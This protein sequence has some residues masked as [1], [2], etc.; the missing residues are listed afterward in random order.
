MDKKQIIRV[1]NLTAN[2]VYYNIP[3]DNI[4]R[5]FGPFEEK[6]LTYEEIQK[7]YYQNGGDVLI[8][9]YLQIK[10]KEVALEFGVEEESFENEYSWDRE[11]VDK[12]LT[13]EH[14][15][16]LH[17]ALDFAPEGIVDLI[18]S[19]AIRLR[20]VDINKR[21][22]IQECTGKNINNMIQNQIDLEKELGEEKKE[23]PKR[24]RVTQQENTEKEE[25]PKQRRA[26]QSAEGES[27]FN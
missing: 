26:T 16:V 22:L 25:Q 27:L 21:N 13:E 7:L 8:K 23:E 20:I 4:H 14:I 12:V 15:D 18:I 19:E 10:N 1:K 17:D 11:K 9:D 3:E 5:K 24:R 6:Q 2:H